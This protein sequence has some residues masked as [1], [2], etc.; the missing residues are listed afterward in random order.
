MYGRLTIVVSNANPTLMG[1]IQKEDYI[2]HICMERLT[3]VV[4]NA[5]PTKII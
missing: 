5:N 1:F 4:S 2:E 3:I